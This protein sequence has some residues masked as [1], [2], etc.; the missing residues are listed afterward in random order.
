MAGAAIL[1]GRVGIARLDLTEILAFGYRLAKNGTRMAERAALVSTFFDKGDAL[2]VKGFLPAGFL[3]GNDSCIIMAFG[4]S[5]VGG[6]H[7]LAGITLRA[8]RAFGASRTHWA[9]S[10]ASCKNNCGDDK[11]AN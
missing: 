1:V 5:Q 3:A 2:T 4:T 9:G 7:N 10:A 6:S 11:Y 8:G